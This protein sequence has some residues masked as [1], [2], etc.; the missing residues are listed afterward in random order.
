MRTAPNRQLFV[1]SGFLL[2]ADDDNGSNGGGHS[3]NADH[4][5][6]PNAV[7]AGLGQ[8]KA[9]GVYYGQRDDSRNRAVVFFHLHGVAV[10]GGGRGQQFN[11][12]GLAVFASAVSGNGD[13]NAV[14]QECVA[15]IGLDFS[16]DI[17][18]V[19]HAPDADV[20]VLVG[21]KAGGIG[22]LG[23]AGDIVDAVFQLGSHIVS[24]GVVAD[25]ELHLLKVPFLVGE[26][27]FQI[28]AVD[29]DMAAVLQ[30]VVI[31]G[32][33]AL[34]GQNDFVIVGGVAQNSI[35]CE[36]GRVSNAEIALRVAGFMDSGI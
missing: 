30:R 22:F 33:G 32:V 16:E 29:I 14:L 36:G 11:A 21:N 18:I 10:H 24:V 31:L 17:G 26:L 3:Q 6:H 23:S 9:L 7:V 19:L 5:V 27:L 1:F 2:A 20:A 8:V 13:M 34:P 12:A 25:G 35:F 15:F 28:D 4:A